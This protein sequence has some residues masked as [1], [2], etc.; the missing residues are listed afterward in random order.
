MLMALFMLPVAS[1]AT[2]QLIALPG[3][4]VICSK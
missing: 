4:Q 1:E 2:E 3:Q